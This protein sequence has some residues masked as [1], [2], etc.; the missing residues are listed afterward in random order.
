MSNGDNAWRRL[1]STSKLGTRQVGDVFALFLCRC[2]LTQVGA[3]PE[4]VLVC[5]L[6]GKWCTHSEL[7]CIPNW[8]DT[9][10]V[11]VVDFKKAR[12]QSFQVKC[13]KIT[14]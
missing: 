3:S 11:L 2:K 12:T 1:S 14:I 7:V 8:G 5:M 13:A 4:E 6:N 10:R 9:I